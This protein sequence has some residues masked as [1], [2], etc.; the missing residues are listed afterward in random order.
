MI[1]Y[2]FLANQLVLMTR[3]KTVVSLIIN[4][5]I[6]SEPILSERTPHEKKNPRVG[7][8]LSFLY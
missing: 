6:V 1:S 4:M 5:Q 8:P 3:I 2:F 7:P